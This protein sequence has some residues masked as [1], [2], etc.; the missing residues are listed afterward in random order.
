MPLVIFIKAFLCA[1]TIASYE[2]SF[3]DS[4]AMDFPKIDCFDLIYPNKSDKAQVSFARWATFGAGFLAMIMALYIASL[5]VQSLWDQYLQ[6]LAL[7]GG[8][9]PGVFALG[10]L[11]RKANSNGVLIGLLLSIVITWAVQH[12]THVSSFLHGFVAIAS[13]II[14]GYIASLLIPTKDKAQLSGL[15]VWD[16]NV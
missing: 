13:T 5:N 2:G 12:Y 6:L 3:V 16:R 8:G 11:T 4:W 1:I 10:L 9:L 14:I 15:T 7:I